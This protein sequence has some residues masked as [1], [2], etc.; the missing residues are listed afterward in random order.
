MSKKPEKLEVYLDHFAYVVNEEGVS[1]FQRMT[2][3]LGNMFYS[4]IINWTAP[5][6]RTYRP[7]EEQHNA[8][9]LLISRFADLEY[10]AKLKDKLND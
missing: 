8:M 7:N 4:K 6:D 10:H 3:E 2:D 5:H 1:V 9:K